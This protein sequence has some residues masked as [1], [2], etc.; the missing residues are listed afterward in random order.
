MRE[1]NAVM[2]ME[3]AQWNKVSIDAALMS[4]KATLLANAYK[5][6]DVYR[7]HNTKDRHDSEDPDTSSEFSDDFD[8][9][10]PQSHSMTFHAHVENLSEEL[11]TLRQHLGNLEGHN[12]A[13]I[14]RTRSDD[15]TGGPNQLQTLFNSLLSPLGAAAN[16]QITRARYG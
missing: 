9:L 12:E 5:D 2:E 4:V 7:I 11:N 6:A 8:G 16:S 15:R 10:D 14:G 13:R 1:L 3:S